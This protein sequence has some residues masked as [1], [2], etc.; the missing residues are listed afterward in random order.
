MDLSTVNIDGSKIRHSLSLQFSAVVIIVPEEKKLD[1]IEAA[2]KAGASGVTVLKADGIG[3]GEMSNF[4]RTSFEA[5]E[6]V[7]LFLLP[8]YLVN[9]VI[10]SIIHTLHITSSGKGVAFAF[11][12]SHMKG[13]SLSKEALFKERAYQIDLEKLK[14]NID[15]HNESGTTSK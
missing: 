13:I 9:D 10:K 7:L 8:Q 2:N 5:N 12:L 3:L 14:D 11:P 15:S 4:Y 6:V 1:A